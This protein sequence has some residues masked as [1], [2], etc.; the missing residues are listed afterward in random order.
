GSYGMYGTARGWLG[1]QPQ[2]ALAGSL[3]YA[4]SPHMASGVLRSG[5]YDMMGYFILPFFALCMLRLLQRRWLGLL[6]PLCYATTLA[7]NAKWWTLIIG[8]TTL[9]VS[10][11]YRTQSGRS[12]KAVIGLWALTLGVGVALA[13]PKLLPLVDL[14]R[15]DLVDQV[16]E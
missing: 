2:S 15:A 10:L 3:F 11:G 1:L 4:T 5:D 13:A 16:K 7:D 6:L 14:M 9:L 12:F 8:A